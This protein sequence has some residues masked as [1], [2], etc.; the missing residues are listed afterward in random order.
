MSATTHFDESRPQKAAD[1]ILAAAR[2][3]FYRLGIRS[4]GVEEVVTKAGVTKPSL[5]RA[6]GSKD[7]LTSAY[8]GEYDARF[9]S[10]FE[11]ALSAHPGDPEGQLLAFVSGLAERAAKPG[12][13][14]CGLTNACVEYPDRDHSA[15][16]VPV[17]NKTELRRRLR[18][19]A[20][21][22]GAGEPDLL[23]DGLLL[24]IEGAYITV[25]IFGDHGPALSLPDHVDRLIQSH[26]NR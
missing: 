9:W 18:Q 8:L 24:L 2:D 22:M 14:G 7:E 20:K 10:L 6:F 3:L 16:R 17:A 1:R 19:M 15:R 5:Y 21:D 26:V 25:H 13:R 23:G 11:A 12:Y 4:V